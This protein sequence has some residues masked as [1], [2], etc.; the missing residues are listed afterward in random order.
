MVQE[1]TEEFGSRVQCPHLLIKASEG[2][3]YM[4]DEKY[5]KIIS[6]FMENNPH[7]QYEQLPGGHHLHLNTP[8]I[9]APVINTFLE[10]DF[11]KDA[12]V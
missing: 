5:D 6:V 3:K 12:T 8:E 10:K 2:S 9:V 7:F 11:S 4:S 1:L